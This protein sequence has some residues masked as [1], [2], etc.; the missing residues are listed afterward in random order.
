MEGL[1]VLVGLI[2]LATPVAVVV[3]I[4]S[5]SRL[6]KEVQTLRLQTDMLMKRPEP[7]VAPD[8]PGLDP[9]REP[10]PEPPDTAAEPA[11]EA[12][13]A[14]RPAPARSEAATIDADSLPPLSRG[15]TPSAPRAPGKVDIFAAWLRDNW[16]YAAAAVSLALAGIFLVQYGVE[17]GL[18]TPRAR[19]AAALAFG[20][21]LIG[22]GEWIRRR[23]GDSE[24]ASTAYL[25]SV[26]S[27][28]GLVSLMG[29]IL[30]ARL[31]YGLITPGPALIALF[32]VALFGLVLGWR[33]GPLLAAVGLIGGMAAPFLVGGESETPEWLLLYFALLTALGLGI[34]TLR[35]WAWISVLS[36]ALGFAAGAF[37]TFAAPAS[38]S[39]V[40]SFAGYGCLL[41]LLAV[42]IPARSPVPDQSGPSVAESVFGPARTDRPIFPVMLSLGALAAA[43]AVLLQAAPHSAT[44]WWI[45]LWLASGLATLFAIWSRPA[46]A[47]QDHAALPALLLLALVF[48][49]ELNAPV[50]GALRATLAAQ[51]GQTETRMPRDISLI[52]LAAVIPGL[53]AAWRSLKGGSFRAVWAGAAALLAP[54]AGLA[55][56]LSWRP[57]W[58]IGA[59]PWALHALA[60]AGMMTALA[61]RFAK[62]DGADRLR[63]SLATLS[64]LACIAFAMTVLLTAAALTLALAATVVAAAAL[65]RRFGLP[66]MSGFIAAGIVALG[67]RLTLDP[68][69]DWA[70]R[71]SLP[72]MLATYGG[73]L[74]ALLAAL[75]LIS[76]MDRP[77]ARI[78]LESAAWS[79]GGMVL[80]LTLYHLIEDYAGHAPEDA[81]WGLGLHATIWIGVALAQ[82]DRLRLAGKVLRR[83]RIAL[84]AGFGLLAGLF[85][86]LAVSF[87]NPLIEDQVVSGAVLL[88]TLIP[89]YLLPAAALALGAWRMGHLPRMVRVGLGLPALALALLWTGLEI[90]HFWQGGQLMRAE[91]GITQ[92]ELYS[93]TVALLMAG[94]GLFYQALAR[95][96]DRLRRAGVAVIA[97]AVAKVFLID[98]SGLDGLARVFSF[99][100]LGLSLAGLA[101]FNRWVQTRATGED[102]EI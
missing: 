34:D 96:S 30:A 52:L 36:L 37:L 8:A 63:A 12:T 26:L 24:S 83:V 31:L 93:Y 21:A 14:P 89:A 86:A 23:Y 25:P 27:G 50:T 55:L 19:V 53:A 45:A 54:L 6:R 46:P 91:N 72:E 29:G 42:V 88:N 78:F 66:L 43:C 4:V 3:L 98:I 59:W 71:V 9:G 67:I 94:A 5:H 33:H 11:P 17:T 73:S 28:A 101:W 16:F 48:T 68:G 102:A 58:Q 61:A 84:A 77:R 15:P 82:L 75:W 57:A 49:P 74:A 65:D 47:L 97:L 79:V 41:A 81:H 38:E 18:L 56:E 32:A 70:L 62:A 35:R 2:V 39:L 85:L 60:L 51:E 44:T 76:G 87:G 80:S 69:L 40:A 64:A 99:L 92:P 95:R 13:P 1:L 10:A 20:A 100:L 22:A 90:R 7:G